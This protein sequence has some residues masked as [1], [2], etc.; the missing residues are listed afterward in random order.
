M[1][2][3]CVRSGEDADAE[4][5]GVALDADGPGSGPAVLHGDGLD[6]VGGCLGLALHA[7]NLDGFWGVVIDERSSYVMAAANCT[8]WIGS[9]PQVVRRATV[10]PVVNWSRRP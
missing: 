1:I 4:H 5:S 7:V 8:P 2:G 6:V 9:S 3:G 10:A